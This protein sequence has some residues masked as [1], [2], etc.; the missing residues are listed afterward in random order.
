[1]TLCCGQIVK[2]HNE[3]HGNHTRFLDQSEFY[4]VI[5]KIQVDLKI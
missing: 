4:L 2:F 1:M 3:Y 5:N